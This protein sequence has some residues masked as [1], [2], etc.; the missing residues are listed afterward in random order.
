M[1]RVDVDSLEDYFRF[2]PGRE[3]D[4]RKVDACLRKAAPGLKRY[5]H[6]GTPAGQP[7][8]RFKMI[9]YGKSFYFAKDRQLVEWPA[10][11]VALQKN[12]I[13][14]YCAI[15]KGGSPLTATYAGQLGESRMGAGNFSF[16]RFGDLHASVVASF[17][18]E[19][20]RIFSAD[21]EVVSRAM[22]R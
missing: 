11:G 9:G 6:R 4:L 5:F 18:A 12:Y 13:S 22:A 15:T 3:T 8:M 17:F 14:V 1:F 20:G 19:A 21:P 2:D 16:C 10:I 7:G